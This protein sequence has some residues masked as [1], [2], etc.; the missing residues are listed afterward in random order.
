MHK[1]TTLQLQHLK[2]ILCYLKSTI[3]NDIFLKRHASLD[4]LEYTDGDKGGNGDDRTST[5]AF[6]I[7]FG[8]NP[9]SWLSKK[10]RTVA[11]S[12]TEAKYQTV[13]TATTEI[14]WLKNILTE[15]QVNL[16]V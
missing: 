14:M 6:N 12:S 3:N 15:L 1:P 8:G 13:T 10:Q 16:H 5:F 4:L 2:R 7:F 11:R 9:I